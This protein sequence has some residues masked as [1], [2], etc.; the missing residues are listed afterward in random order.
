VQFITSWLNLDDLTTAIIDTFAMVFISTLFSSLLGI[1][2]G[3]ILHFSS[4]SEKFQYIYMLL[5]LLVNMIRSIPFIILIILLMP[6]T[7]ILVGTTIG[8]TGVIPVLVIGAIPFVARLIQNALDNV[9]SN[10]ILMAKSYGANSWQLIWH[11]LL[12]EI[13]PQIIAIIITTAITLVAYSAMA[14]VV[15]GG[16]LGDL[17]LRYGYQRY[18]IKMMFIT[19]ILL[20]LIVQLIQVL[21]DK[22]IGLL[23]K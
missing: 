16:G 10:L 14:G 18:D 12:P 21:G 6:L 17:A 15:G 4:K 23:K 19:V 8:V 1:I 5:S 13:T 3:F 20:I 11:I 9:D 7:V 22:F 2:L